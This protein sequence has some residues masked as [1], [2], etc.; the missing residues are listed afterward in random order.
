[1]NN[2]RDT[3]MRTLKIVAP[4][5]LGIY[6]VLYL[7]AN[8]ACFSATTKTEVE[9]SSITVAALFFGN[10]FG[11]V[12]ERALSILITLSKP[13]FVI[14]SFVIRPSS[15]FNHRAREEIPLLFR[16]KFCASNW[17]TGKSP[18]PGLIIHLILSVSATLE[19]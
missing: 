2:V 15:C 8:V 9:E 12:A 3:T 13:K 18:L 14:P 17:P 4:L 16:N 19:P 10:V 6:V 11:S 1:M 5:G 7:L